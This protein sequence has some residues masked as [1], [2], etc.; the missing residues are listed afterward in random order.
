MFVLLQLLLDCVE[1]AVLAKGKEKGRESVPCSPASPCRMVWT[2]PT[3]SSQKSTGG[4]LWN[5]ST[6]G[7]TCSGPQR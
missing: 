6:N 4:A 5:I 3:S 7:S 2:S 1:C